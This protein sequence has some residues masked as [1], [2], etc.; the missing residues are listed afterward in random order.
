MKQT[1]INQIID[2]C[3]ES[4]PELLETV[5]EWKMMEILERYKKNIIIERRKGKIVGVAIFI[6]VNDKYID[7]IERGEIK[8]NRIDELFLVPYGNNVLFIGVVADGVRTVLRGLKNI[9]KKEK[10]RRLCWYNYK[11]EEFSILRGK[12][13]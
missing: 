7:D 3:Y 6:K 8:Y 12:N 4:H 9:I 13:V 5:P 2:F 1:K 10:P 11:K